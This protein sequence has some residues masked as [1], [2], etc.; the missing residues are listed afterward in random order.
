MKRIW[1]LLV[2]LL[3]ACFGGTQTEAESQ[4]ARA[5]TLLTSGAFPIKELDPRLPGMVVRLNA[6]HSAMLGIGLEDSPWLATDV[7][8]DYGPEHAVGGP[9]TLTPE[10]LAV[11][12]AFLESCQAVVPAPARLEGAGYP[13]IWTRREIQLLNCFFPPEDELWEG[14]LRVAE[15]SWESPMVDGFLLAGFHSSSTVWN[16]LAASRSLAG[17]REEY[18][19]DWRYGLTYSLMDLRDWLQDLV[20]G[21]VPQ[22]Q[23]ADHLAMAGDVLDWFESMTR[24][25]LQGMELQQVAS[26]LQAMSQAVRWPIGDVLHQSLVSYRNCFLDRP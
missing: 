26:S 11:R 24:Q 5:E 13:V 8:E 21:S 20:E 7:T 23:A 9:E 1:L 2:G 14:F 15:L 6:F 25:G 4:L 10:L 3:A 19:P 16:E 12:S 17:M 18:A 22:G